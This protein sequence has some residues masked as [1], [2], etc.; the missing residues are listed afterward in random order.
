[1]SQDRSPHYLNEPFWG[2]FNYGILV[3]VLRTKNDAIKSARHRHRVRGT[4]EQYPDTMA[5]RNKWREVFE[6]HK[7]RIQLWDAS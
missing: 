6:V 4:T 7:L 5:N 1:M 2:L 3:D